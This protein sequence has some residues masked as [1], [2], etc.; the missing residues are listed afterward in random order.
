[1]TTRARALIPALGA[2]RG[3]P[4][5]CQ[6]A[7]VTDRLR[8]EYQVPYPLADRRPYVG[9][10]R[11][12]T[13]AIAG[14]LDGGASVEE[15]AE[16]LHTHCRSAGRGFVR[17]QCPREGR[18]TMLLVLLVEITSVF[19]LVVSARCGHLLCCSMSSLIS[20][21]RAPSGLTW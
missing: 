1:M 13:E 19:P 11:I 9:S 21:P 12:S 20:C 10:G 2:R 14:E 7:A 6:L 5:I 16:D 8:D 18:R 15:V 4:R 3:R 17:C